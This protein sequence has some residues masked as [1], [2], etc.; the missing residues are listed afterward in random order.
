MNGLYIEL[1]TPHAK[2][3]LEKAVQ[4]FIALDLAHVLGAY[5]SKHVL[6]VFL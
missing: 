3:R 4:M 2:G 1:Y 5:W 6:S